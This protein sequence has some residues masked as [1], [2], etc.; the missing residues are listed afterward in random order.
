MADMELPLYTYDA[1]KL[2]NP[3]SGIR[4]LSVLHIAPGEPIICTLQEIPTLASATYH[5]LS[6]TWG[7]PFGFETPSPAKT[8]PD[9]DREPQQPET[10]SAE[11]KLSTPTLIID[12]KSALPIG[13]NLY[14]ALLHISNVSSQRAKLSAIWIDAVCINQR[15]DAEIG[16]QIK[17]MHAIYAGA[18]SVVIWLGPD[19][20]IPAGSDPATLR[21]VAATVRAQLGGEAVAGS[22]SWDVFLSEMHDREVVEQREDLAAIRQIEADAWRAVGELASREYWQRLWVWQEVIAAREEPVVLCGVEELAWEDLR[23]ASHARVIF[24]GAEPRN[25]KVR[26]RR[27]MRTRN[28]PYQMAWWRDQY[29]ARGTGWLRQKF[30]RLVLS[31]NRNAFV[32]W[33]ERDKIFAQGGLCGRAE[34]AEWDY[35]RPFQELYVHWWCEIMQRVQEVNFLTFIED[36]GA[37]KLR[38]PMKNDAQHV[39]LPSWVPDLRC[40]LEPPSM[41]DYFQG[42]ESFDIS[43]GLEGR[44]PIGREKSTANGLEVILERQQLRMWGYRFDVVEM[45]G[46]STNE[47]QRLKG[48]PKLVT[49]IAAL[50]RSISNTCEGSP[51]GGD[52]ENLPGRPYRTLDGVLDAIWTSVALLT[53]TD[54]DPS[55][56]IPEEHK[57]RAVLWLC[58]AMGDGGTLGEGNVYTRGM[59]KLLQEL[60]NVGGE[61]L[62]TMIAQCASPH[63]T[64]PREES[65]TKG[66]EQQSIQGSPSASSWQLGVESIGMA[67]LASGDWGLLR[68]R[69]FLTVEGWVGKGPESMAPGDELWIVPG[70][71]VAFVLRRME[72]GFS[73]VGHAYVHG[74]MGGDASHRFRGLDMEEIILN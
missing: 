46:E 54:A 34:L 38:P 23:L 59:G 15:D 6:Y 1:C 61:E 37:R 49:L 70:A 2:A 41:W 64:S 16:C 68:M 48:V 18:S 28:F 74:M 47:A 40:C 26:L 4:L 56:P 35:S 8:P 62:R 57:K 73:Y 65:V 22:A 27:G 72:Q 10:I 69:V 20:S 39:E 17:M 43:R 5:C 19:I 51:K 50:V 36:A 60:G 66:T 29:R 30:G 71:E 25:G 3:S 58:H 21:G 12:A 53:D 13:H 31:G 7:D 32:C 67:A 33:D 24:A 44:F 52:G 42:S 9:Q 63:R 11:R 55:F 14:N 45:C